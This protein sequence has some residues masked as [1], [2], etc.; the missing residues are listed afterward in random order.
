MPDGKFILGK[1]SISTVGLA[2]EAKQDAGNLT[3]ADILAKLLLIK[4]TDGIKKI[5]DTVVISGSVSVSNMIPAVETGLAKEVTLGLIKDTDGIKKITDPLPAG[6]NEIGITYVEGGNA[7]PV[8]AELTDPIPA[9]TN[10]I[11]Q[12]TANAGTNLNTSLLATAAKQL[13][14]GHGVVASQGTAANLNMTEAS[15][16]SIKTAVEPKGVIYQNTHAVPITTSDAIASSQACSSVTVKSLS[17]N[18]VA[19]Y[20]GG[21]TCT[22]ANGFE[23]LPGESVSLDVN[24]IS[25]IYCISGSASQELRWIA[26]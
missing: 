9:G 17:T 16:S 22:V 18:T 11:G 20:V 25:L 10:S 15:A 1:P 23:L 6:T 12:V 4:D 14:D 2:T 13:A 26:I 3:L 24:N 21:S 19:I 5:L 7:L 8:G